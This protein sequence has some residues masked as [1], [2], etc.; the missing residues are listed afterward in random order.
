MNQWLIRSRTKNNE[1]KSIE[2]IETIIGNFA[3]HLLHGP[4]RYNKGIRMAYEQRKLYYQVVISNMIFDLLKFNISN[5]SGYL[6]FLRK[7]D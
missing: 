5:I 3:V 4:L 6:I 1:E 2:F 7:P